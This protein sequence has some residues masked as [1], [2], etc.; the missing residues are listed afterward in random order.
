[1]IKKVANEDII[2][3]MNIV[4]LL[5]Y[6]DVSEWF[7]FN[8]FSN[9]LYKYKGEWYMVCYKF[10]QIIAR[11]QCIFNYIYKLKEVNN[12]IVMEEVC[13]VENESILYNHSFIDSMRNFLKNDEHKKLINNGINKKYDK[14]E[15]IFEMVILCNNLKL[16]YD[17]YFN[18][19]S[20]KM[21]LEEMDN[22]MEFEEIYNDNKNIINNVRKKLCLD[23]KLIKPYSMTVMKDIRKK[24][25]MNISLNDNYFNNGDNLL[26]L[27]TKRDS[28]FIYY[29]YWNINNINGIVLEEFKY[30][31]ENRKV[32]LNNKYYEIKDY[33]NQCCGY[34][35]DII[36]IENRVLG[37]VFKGK[38][39]NG[40][41]IRG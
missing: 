29:D 16:L 12:K 19:Y 26:S 37:N 30:K 25:L 10:R 38:L 40:V 34:S 23:N 1:M 17:I 32:K 15:E 6:S 35:G 22:F 20:E 3:G 13:F 2:V 21:E 36:K 11:C 41:K 7:G 4:E 8:N 31:E 24:G 28:I 14:N 39:Y 18:D 5:E 27:L 9:I 33:T